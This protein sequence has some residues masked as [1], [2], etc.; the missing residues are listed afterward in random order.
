MRVVRLSIC[1]LLAALLAACATMGAAND[2]QEL[3]LTLEE[4]LVFIPMKYVKEYFRTDDPLAVSLVLSKKY[5]DSRHALAK[6]PSEAKIPLVIYMHGCDGF[7]WLH[8]YDFD[9]LVRNNFA[10]LAPNS[11]ARK[12]K[13]ISCY[14]ASRTGGLHRGALYFRLAEAKY[15]HEMA[16]TLQWVDKRNIFM[17]GWSEGGITTAK[18][19]RGD[20]AGRIILGWTCHAGWSE[21]VGISGPRDEPILAV[22]ASRDPWFVHPHV[23]GHCG[24]YMFFR[25]NS[26]SI[27]LDSD[28][29]HVQSLPEVQEKILQFLEANRRP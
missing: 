11:F 18:Y 17:M 26:E 2:P 7:S 6:I 8:Y 1:F 4:A 19:G 5:K 13:P 12:Y 25:R 24:S 29:H 15:A 28:L 10:V 20:L 21:Y 16:K 3:A 14:P 9:F 23:R 27:V 22:V